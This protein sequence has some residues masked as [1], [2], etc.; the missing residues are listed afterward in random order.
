[1][2]GWLK[3]F[4]LL[5][6][7]HVLI[8]KYSGEITTCEVFNLRVDFPDFVVALI[9][10]QLLLAMP[11]ESIKYFC[12][13]NVSMFLF[14]ESLR[15]LKDWQNLFQFLFWSR[16]TTLA[17]ALVSLILCCTT[18][19]ICPTHYSI[20]QINQCRFKSPRLLTY[21]HLTQPCL[22]CSIFI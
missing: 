13:F 3:H 4:N 6:N 12:R 7:L 8:I 18:H 1:M 10:L 20:C 16:I 5:Q 11:L 22:Q 2:S 17:S 21:V 15:K 19:P 14:G 9:C